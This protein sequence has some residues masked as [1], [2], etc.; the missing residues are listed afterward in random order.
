MN[1]ISKIMAMDADI[2]KI[3]AAIFVNETLSYVLNINTTCRK[4]FI[5][6][7]ENYLN[8]S[9]F[10]HIYIE[11]QTI[12][13]NYAFSS[14]KK[15]ISHVHYIEGYFKDKNIIFVP[16]SDWK[17]NV[18]KIIIRNR[19]LNALRT[20]EK[21]ILVNCKTSTKITNVKTLNNDCIDAIGIGLFKLGRI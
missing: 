21:N 19:I 13:K 18:P 20:N 4:E 7:I 2:S 11:D 17:G 15:L 5:Q 3:A 12:Y 10:S 6:I 1:K 16:V 9:Y 8:C 14:I